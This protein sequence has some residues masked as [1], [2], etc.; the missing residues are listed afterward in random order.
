MAIFEFSVYDLVRN[1]WS[2]ADLKYTT[3]VSKN[4]SFTKDDTGV[5]IFGPYNQNQLALFE[6]SPDYKIIFKSEKAYNKRYSGDPR[7]TLVIFERPDNYGENN[8]L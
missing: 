4:S 2:Y 7:N 8:S 6:Q 3:T 1:E 5:A